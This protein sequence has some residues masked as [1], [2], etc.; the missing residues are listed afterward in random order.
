MIR[1]II[2]IIE[3]IENLRCGIYFVE[4]HVDI[5]LYADDI[6][7]LASNK[8]NMNIMLNEL[9]AFDLRKEIKFNG[10]KTSLMVLNKTLESMI[11]LQ[12]NRINLR[13]AGEYIKIENKMKY[14]GIWFTKNLSSVSHI[15]IRS[16]NTISKITMLDQIGFNTQLIGTQNKKYFFQRF[17]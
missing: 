1:D 13:L 15:D 12:E 7:L 16:I 6:I 5:L 17:Y 10:S 9:T 3:K 14:L 4:M 2:E 11:H 8:R